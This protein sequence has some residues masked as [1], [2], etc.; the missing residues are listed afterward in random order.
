VH[1]IFGVDRD[2]MFVD[3]ILM[4][5]VEMAV[6]KI[7]HMAVMANRRVPTVWA[8]LMG[9]V[10]MVLLGTSGHD[11]STGIIGH[12]FSAA[13]SIALCTNRRTWVSESA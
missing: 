1:G 11:N 6:V 2:D 8:M 12:T 7:V 9:V 13:C 3:V 4:H 10:G 5:M